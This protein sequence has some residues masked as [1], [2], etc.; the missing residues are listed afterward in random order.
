M[1][2]GRS[3]QGCAVHPFPAI[4]C[5]N[6]LRGL[7][8][9]VVGPCRDAL[10][11]RVPSKLD[12]ARVVDCVRPSTRVSG[13]AVK[14][15]QMS[16]VSR[17]ST[18]AGDRS[19][20]RSTASARFGTRSPTVR[21]SG[22][23]VLVHVCCRR[24]GQNAWDDPLPWSRSRASRSGMAPSGLIRD[25][26]RETSLAA[27]ECPNLLVRRLLQSS[28]Q[29]S[30]CRRGRTLA[31]TPR[32]CARSVLRRYGRGPAHHAGCCGPLRG[33]A[34]CGGGCGAHSHRHHWGD[35]SRETSPRPP[36]ATRVARG[37]VDQRSRLS[38]RSNVARWRAFGI[39]GGGGS[40]AVAA[41]RIA[42]GVNCAVAELAAWRPVS[43]RHSD[44]LHQA[45]CFT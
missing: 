33:R 27:R 23:P 7:Y 4:A 45:R 3:A 13:L 35:V 20:T 32:L 44:W 38:V 42:R 43:R 6:R 25:V 15:W 24:E 12:R 30:Q 14:R 16:S 17:P 11:E 28:D 39:V 19:T 1:A 21:A 31:S 41:R 34:G 18:A 29:D 10:G 9:T 36:P 22:K 40:S 37:F 26:S 5:A 8:A 2:R